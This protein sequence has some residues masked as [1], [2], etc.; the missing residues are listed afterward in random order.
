MERVSAARQIRAKTPAGT[1]LVADLNPNYRWVKTSG[2]ISTAKWGNLPGG[3]V[4]T[5]PAR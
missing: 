2:I 1:D 3:E 5:T 4:F